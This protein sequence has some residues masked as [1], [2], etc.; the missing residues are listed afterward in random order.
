MF[1]PSVEEML[2]GKQSRYALVIAIARR[3]REISAESAENGVILTEKTV[4]TA[5]ED[6]KNNKYTILVPEIND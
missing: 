1:K 2:S 5:T 3:A 4:L 6:F